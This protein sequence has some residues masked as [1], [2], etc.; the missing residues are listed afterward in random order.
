MVICRLASLT[1]GLD[2]NFYGTTYLG[3]TN[4]S[5]CG[6]G[7]GTVFRITSAGSLTT[8]YN[9]CSEAKCSDGYL[10]D[11]GLARGTDGNF[12]GTNTGDGITGN[13]T[14]FQIT[15]AGV[16]TMLHRFD[17]ISNSQAVLI[18]ST[19]GQ[20][21][22]T[23][24]LG[25]AFGNC[26]SGCGTVFGLDNGLGPFVEAVPGAAQVG[27]TVL[28]LGNNLTGTTAIS[29]NGAAATFTAVSTAEIK[30]SVPAGATTGTVTV[31]APAGT[32]KSNMAFRVI[33]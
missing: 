30:T 9:F 28:V 26:T 13:G 29:F 20:F 22:G 27:A 21:Y 18:Q 31:T 19:N 33:E 16:L 12:Y 3:G 11:A 6:G 23:I 25:G 10:P 5:Y 24:V 7:C 2:G 14:I 32:L 15:P 4:T 8:V 17:S 1:Q